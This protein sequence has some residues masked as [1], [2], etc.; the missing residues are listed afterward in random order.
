MMRTWG[1]QANRGCCAMKCVSAVLVLLLLAAAVGAQ[2]AD[3]DAPKN[4][5]TVKGLEGLGFSV[6]PKGDGKARTALFGLPGEGY[7]FV[8]VFDRSGSMGGEGR[9]A[10]KAVKAELIESLKPLD[11]VHQFQ[12]VFY[13][14]RPTLFNPT[15]TPGRLAFAND[16][17]KEAVLRYLDSID[18]EGGTNHLDA[19]RLATSLAPDVV[20][21]LTDGDEP[22]LTAA[23]IE[24]VSNWA[25]GIRI[26][27][28]EFGP[29]ARPAG[30]RFLETLAHAT[31]GQYAYVDLSTLPS[32]RPKK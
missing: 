7:K 29:G 5:S 13:N 22:R 9:K 25:S 3:P 12:I 2:A 27:T 8:Y 16:A 21:F 23:E 6:V 32:A 4:L 24:K 26:N 10:L 15:G 19:L 14:E 18:A 11:T 1:C 30:E 17:N 28:I 20:Y 31:G